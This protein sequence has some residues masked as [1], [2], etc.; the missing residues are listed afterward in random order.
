MSFLAKPVVCSLFGDIQVRCDLSDATARLQ[1]IE[2][3]SAE[4]KMDTSGIV[5]LAQ[6]R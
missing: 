5:Y 4:L 1:Q 2:G 3:F 6:V